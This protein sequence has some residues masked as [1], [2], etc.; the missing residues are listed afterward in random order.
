MTTSRATLLELG[1]DMGPRNNLLGHLVVPVQGRVESIPEGRCG[2]H[3]G[4]GMASKNGTGGGYR[5]LTGRYPTRGAPC[6]PHMPGLKV[7]TTLGC[8]H[9]GGLEGLKDCLQ[10]KAR[11]LELGCCLSPSHQAPGRP[12]YGSISP[13]CTHPCPALSVR[14][15]GKRPGSRT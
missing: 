4:L 3:P 9:S 14:A 1:P 13:P 15:T 11:N 5:R 10:E 12:R 8:S 2:S 6:G 7:A